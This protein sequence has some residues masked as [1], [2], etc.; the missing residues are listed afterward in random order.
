MAVM[1]EVK[2]P[3]E[4]QA[5]DGQGLQMTGCNVV[6]Y[7]NGGE[8]GNAHAAFDTLAQ[9]FGAA[10]AGDHFQIVEPQPRIGE[11]VLNR[12][13]GSRSGFADNERLAEQLFGGHAF[14]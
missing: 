7:G 8:N 5:V 6:G 12:F 11:T 9:S 2:G 1:R 14:F 10:D 3:F 13:Q 4:V